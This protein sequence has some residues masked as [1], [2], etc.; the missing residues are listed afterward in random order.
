MC[1]CVWG[2]GGEREYKQD[3][4]GTL[5][6]S[7]VIY[8]LIFDVRMKYIYLTL[9]LCCSLQIG[10]LEN[11]TIDISDFMCSCTYL[12][13]IVTLQIYIVYTDMKIDT[14]II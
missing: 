2:G 9:S 11:I 12:L 14:L 3:V 5:S 13:L 10:W 7:K 6:W 1:V 4:S 8:F